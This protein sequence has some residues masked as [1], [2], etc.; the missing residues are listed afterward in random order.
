VN[1]G[2]AGLKEE[3]VLVDRYMGSQ[4]QKRTT[5]AIFI[6]PDWGT[7]NLATVFVN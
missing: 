2:H 7:M 1:D 4:T 5:V 6:V 3:T